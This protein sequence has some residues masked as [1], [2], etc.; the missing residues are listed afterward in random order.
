MLN[1]TVLLKT[2]GLIK[3]VYICQQFKI[4]TKRG[5]KRDMISNPGGKEVVGVG[6]MCQSNKAGKGK[7]TKGKLVKRKES[8][9]SPNTSG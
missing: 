2:L 7:R 3:K 9:M 4:A 8:N 5:K 1:R 6:I